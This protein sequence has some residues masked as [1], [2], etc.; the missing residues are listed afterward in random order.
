MWNA[1]R[2]CVSSLRRGHANLLCIVP[3][4]V[5]VLQRQAHLSKKLGEF[6]LQIVRLSSTFFFNF[7]VQYNIIIVI[8][9]KLLYQTRIHIQYLYIVQYMQYA[10]NYAMH[11]RIVHIK[12]E[13]ITA[14]LQIFLAIRKM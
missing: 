9:N 8:A 3:I 11:A 12:K 2:F 7:T 4:L 5:Y 14:S 13:Y 10:T 1:S 6:I